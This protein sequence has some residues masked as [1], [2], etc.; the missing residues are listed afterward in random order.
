VQENAGFVRA[1]YF[2][3]INRF[4][5]DEDTDLFVEGKAKIVP[6][7]NL[8]LQERKRILYSPMGSTKLP[9]SIQIGENNYF[10]ELLTSTDFKQ[11]AVWEKSTAPSEKTEK[12]EINM[13]EVEEVK[14][15]KLGDSADID[16]IT[17]E[18]IKY[19]G[20]SGIDALLQILNKALK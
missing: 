18:V 14:N 8:S 9:S 15:L 16:N 3:A 7:L 2:N 10:Q 6:A 5:T 19:S 17:P 20:Q 4:E 1:R 13:E 12:I 11:E